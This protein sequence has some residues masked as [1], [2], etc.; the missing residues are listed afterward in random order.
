MSVQSN[1]SKTFFL[2]M[3]QAVVNGIKSKEEYKYIFF[4]LS[5][6]YATNEFVLRVHYILFWNLQ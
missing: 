4:Y 3:L 2:E 5:L 6:Y 1:L